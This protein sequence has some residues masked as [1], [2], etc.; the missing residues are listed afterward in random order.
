MT[1][2]TANLPAPPDLSKFD[3]VESPNPDSVLLGYDS[4]V[5]SGIEERVSLETHPIKLGNGKYVFAIRVPNSLNKPHCVRRDNKRYFPSRRDRH[6]YY[7]DVQEIK[8][9]V[10]RTASRQEQ[11]EQLLLESFREL[12]PSTDQP[13]L[14][15]GTI[16][17]FYKNFLVDLTD[18]KLLVAMGTF[19]VRGSGSYVQC[20]F[21]FK[22]LERKA[23]F[24]SIAQLRRN[25][26]VRYSQR[27]P[28]GTE[29]G[30][31][32]SIFPI[33]IDRML[34]NFIA[35]VADLYKVAGLSGPFLLGMMLSTISP[36]DGLYPDSMM[37][38]VSVVRGTISPG[39]YPFPIMTAYDF[40][41]IDQII[42][43]LC[44]QVHQTFGEKA[45]PSFDSSGKW[46]GA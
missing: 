21:S 45:S 20:T 15:I 42:R 40:G 8:E 41:D 2:K 35:K 22:G 9:L 4:S 19:D 29:T 12:Q 18:P 38:Q 14:L 24:D 30:G 3:G 31:N 44:D 10:M 37:P 1:H 7:M 17:V 11:A 27:I 36:T 32:S 25:G 5:V 16:P 23:D 6:L 26:L 43:P 39:K 46:K 33:G 28:R 34:R 13:Y